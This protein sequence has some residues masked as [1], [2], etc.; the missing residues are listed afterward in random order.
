MSIGFI[1]RKIELDLAS[2]TK[3]IQYVHVGPGFLKWIKKYV[4]RDL[5]SELDE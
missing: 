4:A 3:G 2:L 5:A 1:K